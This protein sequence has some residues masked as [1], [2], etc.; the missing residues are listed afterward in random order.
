[1][2]DILPFRRAMRV[3]YAMPL[4]EASAQDRSSPAPEPRFLPQ[5]TIRAR[6]HDNARALSSDFFGPAHYGPSYRVAATRPNLYDDLLSARLC[7]A[8][9]CGAGASRRNH[10]RGL[11]RAGA[12]HRRL[13]RGD[14]DMSAS[15]HARCDIRTDAYGGDGGHSWC[16]R[17]LDEAAG[18]VAAPRKP[19]PPMDY[20]AWLAEVDAR[21]AEQF[22]DV[23]HLGPG[24]IAA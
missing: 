5:R 17:C 8:Q 21:K 4:L 19:A 22:V 6:S 2:A 9:G 10:L 1:M 3:D 20:A 12:V 16:E 11:R 13:H 23:E 15:R 24:R 14:R 7:R 18:E